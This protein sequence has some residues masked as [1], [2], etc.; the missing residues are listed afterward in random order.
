MFY[1]GG[2]DRY[3]DM[4]WNGRDIFI[5]FQIAL[6]RVCLVSECN[7]KYCHTE[8][9]SHRRGPKREQRSQ[10]EVSQTGRGC[11]TVYFVYLAQQITVIKV[12]LSGFSLSHHQTWATWGKRRG[13]NWFA[14]SQPRGVLTNNSWL[15]LIQSMVRS[16]VLSLIFHLDLILAFP[17]MVV[18]MLI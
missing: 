1:W 17:R 8:P 16:S 7:I 12:Q 14:G 15:V 10:R 18:V 13:A 6:H 9:K 4:I 11:A 5:H 3:E 2:D